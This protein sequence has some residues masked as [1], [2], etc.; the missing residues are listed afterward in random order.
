[1]SPTHAGPITSIFLAFKGIFC[2]TLGEWMMIVP[3]CAA[4]KLQ[5][6]SSCIYDT[7][8]VCKHPKI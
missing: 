1:M 3:G 2:P 7:G 6:Y 4:I 8:I 5:D